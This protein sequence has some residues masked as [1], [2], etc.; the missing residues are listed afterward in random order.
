MWLTMT[1][2]QLMQEENLN[3]GLL[4]EI[5]ATRDIDEG[6]E[7]FIDYGPLWKA[8]HEAHVADWQDKLSSGSISASWPLRAVDLNQEHRTTV[9]RTLDEQKLN[10]YPDNVEL[11]AFLM[12]QDSANA[13]SIEEPKAWGETVDES[14]FRHENLFAVDIISRNDAAKTYTVKW[15]S[16]ED[17]NTYVEQVPHN[18]F[19]FVDKMGTSDEF[20]KNEPF[21][22]P[23]GLPDEIYPSGWRDE[24][25]S[26]SVQ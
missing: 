17:E 21:R 3:I 23:I 6:E 26:S 2:E 9:F 22:H 7:I 20:V 8:A 12:L 5:V 13:G 15:I 11:R 14:A 24:P 16:E 19:V 25:K 10:P 4:I 18:A 1:P